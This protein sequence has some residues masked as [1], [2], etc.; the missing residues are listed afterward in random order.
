MNKL[1]NIFTNIPN[2]LKLIAKIELV[3]SIILAIVVAIVSFIVDI[4]LILDAIVL[5]ILAIIS[6][7]MLYG[8]A[9]LIETNKK[10]ADN[11]QSNKEEPIES[12]NN[13]KTIVF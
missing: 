7:I 13:Q 9:E 10:I 8:F 1:F 2:K 11:L 3:A 6:G 4:S 5:P 12:N